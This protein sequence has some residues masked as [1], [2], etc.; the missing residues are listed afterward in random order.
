M[1]VKIP[2]D[3]QRADKIVGPLTLKQLIIVGIGGGIAY[4]I[5]VTLAPDYFIEIWLPPVILVSLVTAAFAFLKIHSMTFMRYLGY[6]AEFLFKPRRRVWKQMSGDVFVSATRPLKKQATVDKDVEN[7]G[8]AK[9][10]KMKNLGELTKLVD[11]MHPGTKMPPG[12][13]IPTSS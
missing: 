1:Q 2:Q 6:M 8:H 3:V 10:E 9:R 13:K 11:N 12:T 7:R 4:A 5:Y